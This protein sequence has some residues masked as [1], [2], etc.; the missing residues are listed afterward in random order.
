MSH[1]YVNLQLRSAHTP[2]DD[3]MD[4]RCHVL[5]KLFQFTPYAEASTVFSLPILK[6]KLPLADPNLGS[7]VRV[8]ILLG[9]EDVIRAFRDEI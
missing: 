4:V 5:D 7:P 1:H 3:S 6:G 2:S 9:A 8:D